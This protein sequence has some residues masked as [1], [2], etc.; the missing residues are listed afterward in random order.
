MDLIEDRQA[1]SSDP[2]ICGHK[3][4]HTSDLFWGGTNTENLLTIY[5]IVFTFCYC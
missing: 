1:M 2:T 3:T 4:T 5:A